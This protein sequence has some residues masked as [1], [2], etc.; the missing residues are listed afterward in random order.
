MARDTFLHKFTLLLAICMVVGG[1]ALGGWTLAQLPGLLDLETPPVSAAVAPASPLQL[2]QGQAASP[3]VSPVADAVTPVSDDALVVGVEPDFPAALTLALADALHTHRDVLTST[4]DAPDTDVVLTW[5]DTD[6]EPVFNTFFAA[7]TRF[8]T[9][10]LTLRTSHIRRAWLGQ[11]TAFSEIAVLDESLPALTHLLGNPSDVVHTYSS[12]DEVSRCRLARTQYPRA[13]PVRPVD[14][15][16]R[17][18]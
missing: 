12:M 9:I 3:V 1:L 18:L 13:G 2:Q 14:A 7:A 10:N 4:V 15:G 6:A 11:S 17:R 16:A 5:D 8:D